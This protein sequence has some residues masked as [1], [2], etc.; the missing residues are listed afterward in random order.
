[1]RKAIATV[2][3]PSDGSTNRTGSGELRRGLG[4][5]GGGWSGDGQGEGQGGEERLVEVMDQMVCRAGLRVCPPQVCR[6]ASLSSTRGQRHRDL[7]APLAGE[8]DGRRA[9]REAA[10]STVA[11]PPA[12]A[13]TAVYD[14][15]K[16]APRRLTAREA[17]RLL[18]WRA[19]Y[20]VGDLAPDFFPDAMA[21][22]ARR[23][24]LRHRRPGARRGAERRPRPHGRDPPRSGPD[25]RPAE[26]LL[27]IT[28]PRHAAVRERA[29]RRSRR[30]PLPHE[31]ARRPRR[32][33]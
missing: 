4:P 23:P 33:A 21:D 15:F 12:T 8:V 28:V 1:M 24:R 10:A 2:S 7:P 16:G 30:A 27:V 9:G 18:A 26:S 25:A 5:G 22:R 6:R 3:R 19:D 20:A 32:R 31:P 13:A 29:G 17:P 14:E 11:A